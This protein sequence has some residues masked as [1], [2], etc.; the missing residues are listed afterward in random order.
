MTNPQHFEALMLNY[1]NMVFSTAMRL[2][3]N[4][5]E[6]EDIAQEVFLRAYEHFDQLEAN[7]KAG[8]WLR[9]VATNLSL[10]HLARYRS[11][12]SFFSE[13]FT[14]SEREGE[15]E[16]EFP[17][18]NTFEADL[19]Q[20]DRQA[21]VERALQKLPP[22]QRV[23]LVLFHLEGLAYEDIAA[24]LGISLAKV[25]TD[26]FRG[27]QALRKVLTPLMTNFNGTLAL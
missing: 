17:A 9:T 19:D 5:A 24:K 25:K 13:L 20:A 4:A 11:R 10:N 12:W 27:R 16:L 22:A 2:V 1:Q 3:A 21:M 7:P 8:G 18:D 15:P 6:A 23:P 26:I 14:G